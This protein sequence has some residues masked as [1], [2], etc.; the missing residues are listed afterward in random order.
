M[1]PPIHYHK[2]PDKK[3]LNLKLDLVWTRIDIAA[4]TEKL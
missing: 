4:H 1:I 3:Q 2:H